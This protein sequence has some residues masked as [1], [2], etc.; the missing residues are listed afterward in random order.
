[1]SEYYRAGASEALLKESVVSPRVL[2]LST[3]GYFCDSRNRDYNNSIYSILSQ[4]GIALAG[5]NTSLKTEENL[6]P[7]SDDGI[8]TALEVSQLNLIGTEL[9][10]APACET[11]IG[12]TADGQGVFGLSRGF[13]IAGAQSIIMSMW[14]IPDRETSQMMESFYR[15]WLS[16]MSKSESLRSSALQTLQ[17]CRKQRGTGHP[18]LWGGFVLLGNP[19]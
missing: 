16:G 9:V 3:H 8:L 7:I 14:K 4:S 12:E 2:H 19:D 10:V 15:N 6:L 18:L 13:Q 11:G 5:A 1:V 17:I